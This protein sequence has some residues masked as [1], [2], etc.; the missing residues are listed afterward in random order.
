MP[1]GF[2]GSKLLKF[3]SLLSQTF[4]DARDGECG[5][6]G[7]GADAPE[8]QCLQHLIGKF[9]LDVNER[10]VEMI[11]RKVSQAGQLLARRDEGYSFQVSGGMDSCIRI[12]GYGHA[13]RSLRALHDL[14]G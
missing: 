5:E 6:V 12:C 8:A 4:G 10:I 9:F 2:T 1:L 14:I 13:D 11:E 7:R 3:Y